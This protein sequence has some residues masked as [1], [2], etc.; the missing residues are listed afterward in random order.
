MMSLL[1]LPP[2]AP[3]IFKQTTL[4]ISAELPG[5]VDRGVRYRA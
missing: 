4:G 3:T 1:N 2:S 5:L